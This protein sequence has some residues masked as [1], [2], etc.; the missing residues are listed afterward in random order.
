MRHV[1][2]LGYWEGRSYWEYLKATTIWLCILSLSRV[3]IF[4]GDTFAHDKGFIFKL[5]VLN[6]DNLK[7]FHVHSR[8]N[9]YDVKNL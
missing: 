1:I 6:S 7:G 2:L 4:L 5:K 3:S 8:R 9:H